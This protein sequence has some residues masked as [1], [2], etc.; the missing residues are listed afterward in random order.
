MNVKVYELGM[1]DSIFVDVS[2]LLVGNVLIV[3]DMIKLIKVVVVKKIIGEYL[4]IFVFI[5]WFCK[6]WYVFGYG[7]INSFVYSSCW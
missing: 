1:L 6:F 4:M 3:A 2:G 7:N 5:V